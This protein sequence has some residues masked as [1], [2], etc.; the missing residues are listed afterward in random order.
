MQAWTDV[1]CRAWLR[2]GCAIELCAQT[3]EQADGYAMTLLRA[4]GP[5]TGGYCGLQ[6]R[7]QAR[8]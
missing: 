6:L 4:N 7:I 2:G 3:L 8:G 5:D 1:D